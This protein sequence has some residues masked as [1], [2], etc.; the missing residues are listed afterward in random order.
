MLRETPKW[1]ASTRVRVPMRG[2]GAELFVVGLK[3]V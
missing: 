1:T 2:T 3:A